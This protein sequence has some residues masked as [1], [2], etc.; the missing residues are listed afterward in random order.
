MAKVVS[1]FKLITKQFMVTELF[2]VV[3]VWELFIINIEVASG[4]FD[5]KSNLMSAK[6]SY[7]AGILHLVQGVSNWFVNRGL[8]D[9]E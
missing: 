7:W 2:M 3:A 5:S 4:S 6:V 8:V 9:I 1:C